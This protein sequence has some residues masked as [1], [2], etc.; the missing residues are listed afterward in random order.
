[1]NIFSVGIIPGLINESG[2][3]AEFYLTTF[4]LAI[5]C[6]IVS[7]LL[8]SLSSAIIVSKAMYKED[9]RTHGSGNA[10]LTNILR[11][12]G[13]GAAILTLIGDMGKTAVAIFFTALLFGFSYKS[14]VSMNGILYLSGLSAVRTP[15]TEYVCLYAQPIDRLFW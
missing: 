12:Y 1:M 6:V 7:Y 2:D 8:G 13:K 11:T 14:G 5:I 15:W 3:S 9:I 10:G 4:G